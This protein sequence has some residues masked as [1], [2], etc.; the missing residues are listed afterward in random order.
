G[1]LRRSV[2]RS[3][4]VRHAGHGRR[5]ALRP[6]G[7]AGAVGGHHG[8]ERRWAHP[9][10][11]RA[12]LDPPLRARGRSASA[13][14]KDLGLGRAIARRDFLNGVALTVGGALVS[15]REL[16]ELGRAD[17]ASES[18]PYPP[19]LTGLR[20][21]HDGSFA[22]AQALGGGTL[23]ENAGCPADTGERCGLVVVAAGMSVLA[24]AWDSRKVVV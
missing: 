21:S 18:A 4:R 1:D 16:L 14:N 22:A 17:A 15:P 2:A 24:A 9:A 11:A 20:G 13:L 6:A 23:C 10:R 5:P 19:A 8:V 12:H 3:G 7:P